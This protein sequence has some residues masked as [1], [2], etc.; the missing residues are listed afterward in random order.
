MADTIH[1]DMADSEL[2]EPKGI[3]VANT[4]GDAGK[5]I[6]A[7]GAGTSVVDFLTRVESPQ[8][9]GALTS[10]EN[11][12][13]T[14][15]AA[16]LD[17]FTGVFLEPSQIAGN[18][19]ITTEGAQYYFIGAA[20]GAA[21]TVTLPDP[22]L[23]PSQNIQFVIKRLDAFFGDGATLTVLPFAAETIDGQSSVVIVAQ[24]T[25]LVVVSDGTNWRII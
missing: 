21:V 8:I 6:K 2:H 1:R 18:I 9:D 7:T 10:L 24:H 15:E 16:L 3:Q 13:S 4:P 11:R 17:A 12:A 25:A 22:T 5:V 14:L 19:S 23:A 20:S